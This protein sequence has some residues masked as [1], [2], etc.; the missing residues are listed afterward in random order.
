M[1]A[2]SH[3]PYRSSEVTSQAVRFVR[4]DVAVVYTTFEVVGQRTASGQEIPRR[5]GH[6]CRVLNKD[7][8]RWLIISHFFMDENESV[9]N[10]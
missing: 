3:F 5:H 10:R 4:P 8:G 6:A 7:N 2:D 1:F 9:R